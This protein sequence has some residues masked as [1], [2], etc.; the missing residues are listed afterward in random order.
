MIEITVGS[1]E[2][3]AIRS[4]LLVD[5]VER[6]AIGYASQTRRGDGRIRLLV[7]D[8]ELPHTNDYA[9]QTREAVELRPDF[10]ARVTKRARRAGDSLVFFHSH[11]GTAAPRFSRVDDRGE[12]HLGR[13]LSQRIPDRRH[14]SIV[15]SRGGARGRELGTTNE[16]TI[17]ELGANRTVLFDADSSGVDPAELFD[18]Q[19][20]AF[21]I[22][23]QRALSRLRVGIVG[24]GGTGSIVGQQIAH[25]GV[26][27][28][29]LI[30][31]DIVEATNLNRIVGA[32][33]SDVGRTKVAVAQRTILDVIDG[34]TVDA[35]QGN[36]VHSRVAR[37]LLSC[38]LIF[39]CT[40]SH[41]SRAVLQ[42]VAYQYLVPC[43]DVGSIITTRDGALSGIVGRIQTLAP[44]YGC[45]ACSELLNS[46]EVRR[47]MMNEFERRL[48]PYIAGAREPAPSVISLNGT[49]VSLAV[50]M[51]LSYV[52]G[53][54]SAAR[55]L[56]Y[57]GLK[58]TLR[59]VRVAPKQGCYICSRSGTFARGDSLPL[60]ARLD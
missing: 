51:F 13:F 59:S 56:I 17:V 10:V 55:H 50:T 39:G 53:I 31:P 16:V 32:R 21:G 27:E 57:D 41:G 18:R 47:D 12:S 9:M 14:V 35:I 38:D 4:N 19:V 23:G 37:A 29:V 1:P 25:L 8:Y 24:L 44:G 26:R 20:R 15:V 30:D 28:F 11:P 40:D 33:V 43:I 2:A 54:P 48:D 58:S 60:Y 7:R 34:G 6:C 5:D 36:V 42:Q 45:F 22:D 3:E 52:T 46:E 49:V